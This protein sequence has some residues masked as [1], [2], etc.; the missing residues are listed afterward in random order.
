MTGNLP[1]FM[2]LIKFFKIGNREAE[3]LTVKVGAFLFGKM[4]FSYFELS[5]DRPTGGRSYPLIESLAQD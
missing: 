5:A 3:I 4:I 2:K 1:K